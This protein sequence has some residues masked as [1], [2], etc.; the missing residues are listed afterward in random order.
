VHGVAARVHQGA[1]GEVEVVPDVGE[2]RQRKTH[3]RFDP[4]HVTELAAV[5][6]L[7]H[8]QCHRVVPVVEGLHDDQLTAAAATSRACA[9]LEVNGFSQ[10]TCLPAASAASVHRA[11]NPLGS[12]L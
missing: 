4:L 8:A 6:D 2:P 11:C 10:S 12:G 7:F 3:R 9:A 1:A 5:N